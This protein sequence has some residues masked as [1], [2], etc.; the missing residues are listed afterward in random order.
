MDEAT[1]LQQTAARLGPEAKQR[2]EAVL[3]KNPSLASGP[4]NTGAAE[5]SRC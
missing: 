5:V 3:A 1:L 4:L 2:L